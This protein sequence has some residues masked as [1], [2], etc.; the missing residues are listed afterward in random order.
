MTAN[1]A[2]APIDAPRGPWRELGPAPIHKP[3]HAAIARALFRRVVPALDVRVELPDGT[4]RVS[5]ERHLERVDAAAYGGYAAKL[6]V[7]L[8]GRLLAAVRA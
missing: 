4:I 7:A 6:G 5:H 3:I 1:P 2:C 8:K